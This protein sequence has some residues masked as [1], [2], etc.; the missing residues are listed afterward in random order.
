MDMNERIYIGLW[1]LIAIAFSLFFMSTV[2]PALAMDWDIVSAI[3]GGFVNPFAAGYST[4]V[5]LCWLV[6]AIWVYSEH[7]EKGIKHGWVCLLLGA[8]PSVAVGFALYL[9]MRSKQLKDV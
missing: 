9:I 7:K 8:V 3:A 2:V 4:D 1:G 6:L 5:I